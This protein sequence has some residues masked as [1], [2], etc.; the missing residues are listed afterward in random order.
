MKHFL[1]F[2]SLLISLTCSCQQIDSICGIYEYIY[3]DSTPE[4]CENQYIV[5]EKA[6]KGNIVGYYYGT[7]DEFDE[8]R[9]GYLP[10]FF[11]TRMDSLQI[12]KDTISFILKVPNKDIFTQPIPLSI[13][14]ALQ[15]S[16]KQLQVWDVAPLLNCSKKYK[17]VIKNNAIFF[18]FEDEKHVLD[19]TF[20][21]QKT[22]SP[23]LQ[24]L[25]HCSLHRTNDTIRIGKS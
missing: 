9:E 6:E 8:A 7:T 22:D 11:V 12:N 23:N 10:G 2:S 16:E 20:K 3:P 18:Y 15:A 17:G 21:K 24:S 14:T 4:L 5:L 13:K 19:K 25:R 1:L